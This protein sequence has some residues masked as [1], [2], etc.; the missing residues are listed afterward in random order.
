MQ[1]LTNNCLLTF[2]L[3]CY[4]C[5]QDA[6]VSKVLWKLQNLTGIPQQNIEHLQLLRYEQGQQYA[7][8]YDFS[9]HENERPQGVRLLTV[10]LYLNDVVQGGETEFTG[11]DHHKAVTPKL[12]RALVWPNVQDQD[13]TSMDRRTRHRALPLGE[14]VKY[15]ANVWFHQRDF[16]TPHSV[17]CTE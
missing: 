9:Q 10:F 6:T 14:G 5:E 16:K 17:G 13:P 12:G 7:N 1:R 2:L 4:Q 11:L 3:L 15:G 8:H